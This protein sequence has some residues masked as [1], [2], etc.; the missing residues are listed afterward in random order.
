MSLDRVCAED[1]RC[2]VSSDDLVVPE[3]DVVTTGHALG[4]IATSH[5]HLVFGV[6][7][8]AVASGERGP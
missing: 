2:L 1:G 6:E 3:K 8:L 4:E 5:G 7:G